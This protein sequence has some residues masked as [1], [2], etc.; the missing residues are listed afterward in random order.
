MIDTPELS[1][2]I[3]GEFILAECDDVA[4]LVNGLD[5]KL[6]PGTDSLSFSKT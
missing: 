6:V 4:P 1:L 2:S 3:R 5:I